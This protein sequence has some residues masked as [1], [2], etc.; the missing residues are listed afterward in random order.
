MREVILNS[1]Y[2]N[3]TKKH[4]FKAWSWFKFNNLD[5]ALGMSLKVYTSVTKVLEPKFKNFL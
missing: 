2:K 5:V 3:L 4:F 1:I